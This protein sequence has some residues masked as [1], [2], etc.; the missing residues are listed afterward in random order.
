MIGGK[1]NALIAALVLVTTPRIWWFLLLLLLPLVPL[2]FPPLDT[3][4]AAT[5]AVTCHFFAMCPGTAQ[6]KWTCVYVAIEN[7]TSVEQEISSFIGGHWWVKGIDVVSPCALLLPILT[8]G[9][10]PLLRT[11][12]PSPFLCPL[13]LLPDPPPSPLV[14]AAMMGLLLLLSFFRL[15]HLL[16]PL[17]RLLFLSFFSA[18]GLPLSLLLGGLLRVINIRHM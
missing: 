4:T 5:L 2:L 13:S 11:A 10:L 12:A 1:D 8:A 18:M 9:R 6:K 16:L 14:P 7:S 17:P 3:F 15:V